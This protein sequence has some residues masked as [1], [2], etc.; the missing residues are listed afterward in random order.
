MKIKNILL[1]SGIF[2]VFNIF[3]FQYIKYER[4]EK[5]KKL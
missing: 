5:R 1:G 3:S 2:T 4:A